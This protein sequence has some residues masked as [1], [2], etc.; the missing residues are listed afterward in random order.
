LLCA[1]CVPG[2]LPPCLADSGRP[3]VPPD[4]RVSPGGCGGG[5]GGL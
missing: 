4:G 1:A 2:R 3:R 5:P